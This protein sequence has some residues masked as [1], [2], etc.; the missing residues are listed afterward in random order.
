MFSFGENF[1]L[2]VGAAIALNY[3]VE[4]VHP[5]KWIKAHSL[6]TRSGLKKSQWKAKLRSRAAEL[7]PLFKVTLD[8]A[9]ALLILDAARRGLI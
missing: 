1:G 3:R 2:V 8:N 6:G 5:Q 7:Y 9:D 4:R